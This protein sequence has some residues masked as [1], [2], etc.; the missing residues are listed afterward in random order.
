MMGHVAPST[1][2]NATI[3][4]QQQDKTLMGSGVFYAIR[5]KM[6]MQDKLEA[7]VK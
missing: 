4:R 2:T 3:P 1:D 5:A 6:L 7:H